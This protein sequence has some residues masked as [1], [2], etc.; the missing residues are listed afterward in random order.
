VDEN[1]DWGLEENE[2]LRMGTGCG[3]PERFGIRWVDQG[4][5]FPPRLD[6]T[7]CCV[8]GEDRNPCSDERGGWLAALSRKESEPFSVPV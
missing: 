5:L 1:W 6:G 7:K 3:N 4:L 8:E 2:E